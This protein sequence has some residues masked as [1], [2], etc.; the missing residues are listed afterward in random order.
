M[1]K[2]IVFITKASTN[3]GIGHLQRTI[4]L[5]RN[6]NKKKFDLFII[7]IKKKYINYLDKKLFKE[8]SSWE[9]MKKS[10]PMKEN[11]KK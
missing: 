10:N 1:K 6:L 5:A 2:K 8:K 3:D 7:G 9:K 11:K 4:R